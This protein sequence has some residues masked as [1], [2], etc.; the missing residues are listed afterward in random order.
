[1]LDLSLIS[2]PFKDP[3]SRFLVLVCW[4]ID[5]SEKTIFPPPKKTIVKVWTLHKS[6][7]WGNAMDLS[8][9]VKADPGERF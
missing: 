3:F 6:L 4:E 9:C 2:V 1:M 8:C 5:K 7:V